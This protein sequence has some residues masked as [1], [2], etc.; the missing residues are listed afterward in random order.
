MP[1]RPIHLYIKELS[2]VLVDIS[3]KV[4]GN[5][6]EALRAV[7]YP[8]ANGVPNIKRAGKE[9]DSEELDLEE[10][11]IAFLAMHHHVASDLRTIVT[12]LMINDDL[13][14]IGELS[15]HI[16]STHFLFPAEAS[17]T[18]CR[19]QESQIQKETKMPEGQ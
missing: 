11:C 12:I 13:V 3:D 19:E 16:S 1:D 17:K 9:I 6:F 8:D 10:R 14:R 4:V 7:K 5:L 18:L 15:M 2:L